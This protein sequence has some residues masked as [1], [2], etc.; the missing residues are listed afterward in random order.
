MNFK[1][2]LKSR[3]LYFDGGSG[4]Y[5]QKHGLKAGERPELLN[6]KNPELVIGMH[7]AFLEAGANI[8]LTNAFAAHPFKLR[9]RG[10]DPEKIISLAVAHV[11]T[12]IERHK[13]KHGNHLAYTALDLGPIGQFLEPFGDLSF[14]KAYNAFKEMASIG[15]KAGADLILIETMSDT[16]ELKAAVLGAKEGSNLPIVATVVFE[17]NQRLLT[18]ADVPTVVALLEGLGVDALGINCSLGPRQMIPI[19]EELVKYSS[20]PIAVV[21]NAGMPVVENGETVYKIG[22]EEFSEIMAKFAHQG[23]H[24]LGGCCGTTPEHISAL[25]EKTKEI[26]FKLPSKKDFTFASSYAQAVEFGSLPLL[27][28]E[29]INPTGKKWLQKALLEENTSRVLQ[30]VLAQ[31][32]EG[33]DLLDINVGH[34]DIDEVETLPKV[35][36]AIQGVTSLPLQMDSSNEKALARACHYYNGKPLI[37][38]V[39]GTQE[40]MDKIFPIVEKY[41]GVVIGLCLDESGIPSTA[42]GRIAIAK[43]II[44][45][46]KKYGID[47]KDIIIDALALTISSEPKSP[48]I[49]LET[50]ETLEKELG[51]HTI[52]GISNI[53]FGLPARELINSSFFTLALKAGLSSGIVNTGSQYLMDAYDTYLALAGLDEN[54]LHFIEKN[55]DRE[56]ADTKVEEEILQI[57]ETETEDPLATSIEQGIESEAAYYARQALK[58]KEPL[59]I[60][61]DSLVSALNKV[62]QAFEVGDFFLPQLLMSADAASA[63]FSIIRDYLREMDMEEESRGSILIAT[64]QGD[65]HDIGKNITKALLENYGFHVI[66]LGKDVPPKEIL[67]RAKETKVKLIGLSALMTTTVKYMEETIKL[68]QTHYPEATILVG[69]AVLTE[70]YA[71]KIHA[72]YYAFDAMA[73]VRYAEKMAAAGKL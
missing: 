12:A 27:I 20:T 69:G 53:S 16:Y 57:E 67:K 36:R 35:I 1:E 14:D 9:E 33:A 10:E 18:G 11:K 25:V 71:E 30:E 21:P 73:T 3:T 43:K 64:V 13:I 50:I 28:G 49:C 72:N 24:L 63:A 60:I 44:K 22:P 52:L 23:V 17:E 66:D 46:A 7:Q 38:S 6:I 26:P 2:A 40:S 55:R 65:I 48:S 68:L 47:K 19:V 70:D 4:T 37:N 58:T 42:K 51:I 29:R 61:D 59:E 8:V 32:A 54:C 56:L 39:N 31:E 15:E 45:E 34:T 5:L 62:G 41:G